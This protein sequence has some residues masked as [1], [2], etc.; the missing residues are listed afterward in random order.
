MPSRVKKKRDNFKF[1]NC[2]G[3]E[4]EVLLRKPNSAHYGEADG[5]CYDPN[6]KDPKIYISPYLTE[7]SSLNTAIH[8]F[9]H[10]FFWDKTEKEVYSFANTLTK[11][12]F[13]Y[14]KWR[15]LKNA[16]KPKAKAKRRS[17]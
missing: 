6:Q 8:E 17:K 2:Q 16:R 9:A 7:K 12:L 1:K 11:F 13:T 4:F 3:H 10:A 14:R 5:I 15:R